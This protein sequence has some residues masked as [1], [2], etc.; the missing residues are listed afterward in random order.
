M[1]LFKMFVLWKKAMKNNEAMK[2]ARY[3]GFPDCEIAFPML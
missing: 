2:N 1:N 3:W